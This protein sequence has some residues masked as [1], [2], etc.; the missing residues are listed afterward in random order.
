MFTWIH[1]GLRSITKF[2]WECDYIT[3]Y[4]V[5][6]SMN[7]QC[8]RSLS[9][10]ALIPGFLPFLLQ[11]WTWMNAR[12]LTI[13]SGGYGSLDQSWPCCACH[14]YVTMQLA[15]FYAVACPWN[16]WILHQC[17]HNFHL[18]IIFVC[19]FVFF[20]IFTKIWMNEDR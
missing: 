5:V 12:S 10:E 8:S 18:T 2:A 3:A 17:I 4:D 6:A 9:F 1:N 19:L 13:N 20:Q 11:L 15:S 7:E 16:P 14:Y